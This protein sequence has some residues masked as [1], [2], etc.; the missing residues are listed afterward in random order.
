VNVLGGNV[1]S[2]KEN[3]EV[4]LEVNAKKTEY[5]LLSHPESP[6]LNRDI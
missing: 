3:K 6:G 4:G 5:M 1:N 2:I